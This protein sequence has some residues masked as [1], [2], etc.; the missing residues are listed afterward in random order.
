MESQVII[1][2]ENK[3]TKRRNFTDE[4]N[5]ARDFGKCLL[6]ENKYLV[7][8]LFEFLSHLL[9]TNDEV[10]FAFHVSGS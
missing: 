2:G 3:E 10:V 6:S 4:K 5:T 7:S 9:S 1:L 8:A